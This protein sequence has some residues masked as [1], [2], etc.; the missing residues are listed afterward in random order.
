[1]MAAMPQLARFSG[2]V[3]V[4]YGDCPLLSARTIKDLVSAHR[5]QKA[6]LTL[7]TVDLDDPTGY[8]RIIRDHKG[9]I[10]A[11]VEQKDCNSKERGIREANPGIYC[12]GSNFLKNQIKK[13]KNRN[14]QKEYYLTDLVGLAVSGGF[15]VASIKAS[16]PEELMGI[17]T[18]YE[19]ARAARSM[20][21]R[22]NRE[23]C[24]AGI[25]IEDPENTRIEPGVKI[26]KDA[27]IETG[28]RLCGSTVIGPKCVIE[29][30]VRIE[31]SVIKK[32][33]R[34]KQGSVI[35]ESEVGEGTQVGPMAHLRP[36]SVVGK[37]VRIGNFVETKKA[38][39][40]DGTKISHLTY[41]GDA[42]VGRNVNIGCGFITCNYDGENKWLTVI[43]DDVFVGSDTQ[44]VAPVKIG[45]GAYIGSG[46]TITKDVPAGSLALTRASL[47]VK[48]AWAKNK[49][50]RAKR[51]APARK[52]TRR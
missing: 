40:G 8:G 50:K 26:G 27:R 1:V 22:I 19:L 36:G 29:M 3:V 5:R 14:A 17:N 35:E 12:Y 32:N 38:K 15:R 4:V 45:K 10:L 21:R 2:D 18:R 34:V 6:D 47:T 49:K 28:A 7:L 31:D 41:V 25:T 24:E 13:L 20:Q 9:D 23:H 30:N 51:I 37:D 52:K 16:D 42:E 39:I 11:I 44:T 33:V 43:E 48:K 46:S